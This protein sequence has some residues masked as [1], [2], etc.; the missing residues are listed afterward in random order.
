MVPQVKNLPGELSSN[1]KLMVELDCRL[2]AKGFL[3]QR[4]P[5]CPTSPQP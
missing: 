1:E 2:K 4:G 3:G 5:M